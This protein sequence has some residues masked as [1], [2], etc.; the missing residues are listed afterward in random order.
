MDPAALLRDFNDKN[1]NDNFFSNM[2]IRMVKL[3]SAQKR[4]LEEEDVEDYI[5]EDED[6][7][8]TAATYPRPTTPHPQSVTV[9]PNV[10]ADT[11]AHSFPG[12]PQT[13]VTVS[14]AAAPPI[15]VSVAA[16]AHHSFPRHHPH[17][18]ITV[19]PAAAAP[20]VPVFSLSPLSI[21]SILLL[22]TIDLITGDDDIVQ[23][24]SYANYDPQIDGRR[25][26]VALSAEDAMQLSQPG[27]VGDASVTFGLLRIF[28]RASQ[29][30]RDKICFFD[31]LLIG[32]LMETNEPLEEL[33]ARWTKKV[34]IFEKDFVLFPVVRSSHFSLLILVRP[35]LLLQ[36]TVIN[37]NDEEDIPLLLSVD[38]LPGHHKTNLVQQFR[39]FID[40]AYSLKMANPAVSNKGNNFCGLNRLTFGNKL[41][42]VTAKVL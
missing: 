6:V 16:T 4:P 14:P 19:S 18:V 5:F 38:S 33:V 34:D 31:P 30:Q 9:C 7:F 1:D 36:P 25:Y 17:S 37:N 22:D 40:V 28:E 41:R 8:T 12:G 27:F 11:S 10:P 21:S 20:T 26:H 23:Q 24:T 15:V 42:H 32:K 39:N 29:E 35:Y 3:R 2:M 13:S